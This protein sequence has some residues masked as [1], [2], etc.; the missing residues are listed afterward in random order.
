[1]KGGTTHRMLSCTVTFF[2]RWSDL[3]MHEIQV[4]RACQLRVWQQQ[5]R[6]PMVQ[7][8]IGAGVSAVLVWPVFF[9]VP[10]L[11]GWVVGA[12]LAIAALAFVGMF[13]YQRQLSRQKP[14]NA[15]V[16]PLVLKEAMDLLPNED[17][18]FLT[19]D[20]YLER[21]AKGIIG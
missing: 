1:M 18:T 21:H 20:Q 5:Y 7:S 16:E 2:E 6:L 3:T 9:L 8:A 17:H 15:Q 11:A 13:V 4:C 19:T 10:G 14:K 12:V